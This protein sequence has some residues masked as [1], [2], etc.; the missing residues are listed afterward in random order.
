MITVTIIGILAV[1]AVPKFGNL[2]NKTKEGATKGNLGAI[3][4]ALTIYYGDME[5]LYPVSIYGLTVN[6]KYM[7]TLPVSKLPNLHPDALTEASGSTAAVLTDAGGWS[8]VNN[9]TDGNF[10]S[11]WVNCSHTDSK[12]VL[13]TSY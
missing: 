8:Y 9:S 6:G 4:G 1:V 3:R 13:W 5:G 2:I 11:L 12:G 10:G 7:A